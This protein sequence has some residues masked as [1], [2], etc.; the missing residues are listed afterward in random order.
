LLLIEPA[1]AAA[2]AA[3]NKAVVTKPEAVPQG[4]P[5][6]NPTAIIQNEPGRMEPLVA[7]VTS[8]PRPKFFHLSVNVAPATAKMRLVQIAEETFR[9]FHPNYSIRFDR[10]FEGCLKDI[11]SETRKILSC[12]VS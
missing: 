1:A 10:D 5:P 8:A 3:A 11:V 9:T 2:Y 4:I 12:Q 7:T 6:S